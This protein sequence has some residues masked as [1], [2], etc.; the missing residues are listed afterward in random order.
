MDDKH[1]L[2][3]KK[4]IHADSQ[5]TDIHTHSHPLPLRTSSPFSPV[6]PRRSTGDGK[7]STTP[8]ARD[9]RDDGEHR[10]TMSL[11]S[12]GPT[13]GMRMESAKEWEERG[14]TEGDE[15]E[16]EEEDGKGGTSHAL[17]GSLKAS[18]TSSSLRCCRRHRLEELAACVRW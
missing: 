13:V 8:E 10:R 11:A 5:N 3:V 9:E 6:G 17:L 14:E 15:K 12:A 2:C 4:Q 16:E 1:N 7:G 18:T